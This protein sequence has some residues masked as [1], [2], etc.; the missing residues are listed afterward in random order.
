MTIKFAAGF[1]IGFVTVLANR[2]RV[3]NTNHF[4]MGA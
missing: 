1:A 2:D 4:I 3:S